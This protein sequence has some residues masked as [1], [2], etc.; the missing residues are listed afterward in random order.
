ME[1]IPTRT[2]AFDP[3]EDEGAEAEVEED[4]ASEQADDEEGGEEDEE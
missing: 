3:A 4:V 2:S 1:D